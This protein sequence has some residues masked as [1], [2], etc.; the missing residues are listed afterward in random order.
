MTLTC[1]ENDST[2]RCYDSVILPPAGHLSVVEF[3]VSTV[4][5][6][7]NPK[8]RWARTPLD[9]AYIFGHSEVAE[10]LKHHGALTGSEITTPSY[11]HSNVHTR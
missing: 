6:L 3:L 7:K 5:A 9:E 10:Y 1:Y 11:T 4:S 8:D 2:V